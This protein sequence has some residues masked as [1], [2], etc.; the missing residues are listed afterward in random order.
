[1]TCVS[2]DNE[3]DLNMMLIRMSLLA[4]PPSY[5]GAIFKGN[6]R[7]EG[8]AERV[9]HGVILDTTS[10]WVRG[11]RW[12]VWRLFSVPGFRTPSCT[13]SDSF[14]GGRRR[15]RWFLSCRSIIQR[16]H[17]FFK[18]L[19]YLGNRLNAVRRWWNMTHFAGPLSQRLNWTWR[20]CR[21]GIVTRWVWLTLSAVLIATWMCFVCHREEQV[22]LF[23]MRS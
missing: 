11:G 5:E 7:E 17:F 13:S 14:G 1:M 3:H 15:I 21:S 2:C 6:I 4:A 10:F 19:L 8:D 22:F 9:N 12:R 23:V 18:L 16:I 20:H